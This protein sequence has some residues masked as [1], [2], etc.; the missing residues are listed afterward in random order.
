MEIFAGLTVGLL[1]LTALIVATRMFALWR[2]TRGLPELLLGLMLLCATVL[3]YPIMIASSLIPPSKMWPLHVA[4]QV[5]MSVGFTCLLLFTLKVFRPNA[6][7]A[8]CVVALSL[9]LFVAGGVAYFREVTG[10]NPRPPVELLGVNLLNTVPIAFA[11]FWTT[12]ESLSYHRRLL[13]QLRLG[14]TDVVVTNRVWLW[15]QMTLAAGV[16]VIINLAAMLAGSYLSA[17]IVIVSSGLGLVHACC[18]LL[19]FQPPGWYTVW[20]KRRHALEAH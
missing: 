11:Y 18:L 8:R 15:G 5:L 3:G 12:V 2:R 20:L 9:L 19:A 4:G 7:W 17:P 13:L 10:E 6:L 16:A 14:L 1:I